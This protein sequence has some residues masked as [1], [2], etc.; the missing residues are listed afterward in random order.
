MY[1]HR[2]SAILGVVHLFSNG[3]GGIRLAPQN[4]FQAVVVGREHL[5]VEVR[6]HSLDAFLQEPRP[7]QLFVTGIDREEE[8]VEKD[9]EPE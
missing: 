4:A 9:R 7:A 2:G 3:V 1:H 8:G 6:Q 5:A